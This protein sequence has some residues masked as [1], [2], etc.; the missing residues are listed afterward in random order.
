MSIQEIENA[1]TQLTTEDYER[2]RVW[3]ARYDTGTSNGSL[4]E[5]AGTIDS[6]DLQIMAREIEAACET[7][8]S[9]EW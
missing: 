2:L 4:V 6:A 1:I 9:R 5:L 8:D 7:V 3:L